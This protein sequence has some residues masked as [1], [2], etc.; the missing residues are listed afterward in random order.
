MLAAKLGLSA[1]GV[2]KMDLTEQI[3][4][5]HTEGS[6][7]LPGVL[8][9][10]EIA[11]LK[12]QL[13]SA[14]AAEAALQRDTAFADYG[15]LLAAP[16]HGGALLKLAEHEALFAPVNAL[17]GE[18][19]IIHVYTS[20]SLPPNATNYGSRIHHERSD[21]YPDIADFVGMIILLDDFSEANGAT[22]YL[23]GSHK[24][25]ERPDED[26]F[27]RNGRRLIA[28]AGSVYYFDWRLYHAGGENKTH[29][30][31]HALAMGLTPAYQKQKIDLPRAIPAEFANEINAFAKQKL[32]YFSQPPV[33]IEEYY[34]PPHE[35][36]YRQPPV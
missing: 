29:F 20:S 35:R 32:G 7:V 14:I 2:H 21:R 10:D 36:S 8:G 13:E 26:F 9:A 12:L 24:R 18:S 33:S 16:I 23:P 11:A 28:A 3:E 31:R 19:C 34:K 4:K 27:Y 25:R 5:F 22:W 15:M 1:A 6:I 30:W 17:L